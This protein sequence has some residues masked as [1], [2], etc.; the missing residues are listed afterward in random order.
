MEL[1]WSRPALSAQ[2]THA[3]LQARGITLSTV[4]ST[5]ERLTRKGLLARHKSGRAFRYRA[6]V[7]REALIAS[8]L[9]ALS[10]ELATGRLEP[11]LDGLATLLDELGTERAASLR[12]R[13]GERGNG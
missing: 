11:V 8:L 13:L 9:R 5:L 6:A 3:A 7:A 1:A 4:Q 12:A 10:D 2:E